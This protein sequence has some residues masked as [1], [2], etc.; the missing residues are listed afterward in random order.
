M[1][2]CV[3]IAISILVI[4]TVALATVPSAIHAIPFL[5][6]HLDTQGT[7]NFCP[8]P[9][10]FFN[11]YLVLQNADYYVTAVEYKLDAPDGNFIIL[12]YSFPPEHSVDFGHPFSGQSISYWPPLN[13]FG[14]DLVLC[15]MECMT[16]S[17]CPDMPDY[18]LDLVP[19]P[20]SGYLR[21]TF[22]PDNEFFDMIGGSSYLCQ[23]TSPPFLM[24]AQAVTESNI[25]ASFTKGVENWADEYPGGS[26]VM[27]TT[28]PGD[29]IPVVDAIP[30]NTYNSV[31]IL[32]L[33]RPLASGHAYTLYVTN[34]CTNGACMQCNMDTR[35]DFFYEAPI[36]S[37]PSSWGSIKDLKRE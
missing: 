15:T 3:S 13:G 21:G 18:R 29:T 35:F 34:A 27:D 11:A 2:N 32:T 28:A 20:D 19:H 14:G 5:S 1:K 36:A 30:D 4:G 37:W 24:I 12:D 10:E 6:L 22:S 23:Y 8:Y 31:F 7:Q 16:L 9:F 26:Y 25:R 33:G 17:A